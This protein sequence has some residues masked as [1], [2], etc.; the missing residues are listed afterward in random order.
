[1]DI[2][3]ITNGEHPQFSSVDKLGLVIRGA[4]NKSLADALKFTASMNEKLVE[5][6]QNYPLHPQGFPHWQHVLN[7]H[8]NEAFSKF[9]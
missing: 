7:G 5:H 4:M 1:M 8:L 2:D 3:K 9:K 6:Y